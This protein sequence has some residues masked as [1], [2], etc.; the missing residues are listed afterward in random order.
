MVMNK[1]LCDIKWQKELLWMQVMEE[2]TVEQ[3]MEKE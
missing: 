2:E 3:A 1:A